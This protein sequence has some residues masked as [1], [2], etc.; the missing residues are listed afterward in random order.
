MLEFE[1]EVCESTAGLP[2]GG[3]GCWLAGRLDIA[4]SCE[5]HDESLPDEL[6]RRCCVRNCDCADGTVGMGENAPG[7]R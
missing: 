2:G 4:V 5:E 3:G 6:A 1:L 7:R